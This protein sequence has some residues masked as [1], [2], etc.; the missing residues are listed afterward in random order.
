[1]SKRSRVGEYVCRCRSYEFPHRMFGGR[2]TGASW[3]SDY[4]FRFWGTGDCA[5][6][7]S[8]DAGAC[9]VEDG[10]ESPEECAALQLFVECEEIKTP[11][12]MTTKISTRHRSIRPT[13]ATIRARRRP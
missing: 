1:M 12:T 4:W 2:C 10:R 3:V 8:H 11:W 13:S 5:N 6:C 7:T 9:D